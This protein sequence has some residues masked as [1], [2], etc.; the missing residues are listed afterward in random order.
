MLERN[1]PAHLRDPGRRTTF[2]ARD[3]LGVK[4]LYLSHTDNRLR[5]ASTL[6]FAEIANVRLFLAWTAAGLAVLV[7]DRSALKVIGAV[8]QFAPSFCPADGDPEINVRTP[9]AK[10]IR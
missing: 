7:T 2:L 4:P 8:G 6:P 3:P 5:F 1:I 10:S 9:V